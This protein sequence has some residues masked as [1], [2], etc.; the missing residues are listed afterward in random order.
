MHTCPANTSHKCDE[1]EA[2]DLNHDML[3]EIE[4]QSARLVKPGNFGAMEV[5]Q[6][7][8]G[9]EEHYI[10]RFTSEACAL[11]E[12]QRGV[13]GME[14]RALP[15]GTLVAKG[16]YWNRVKG[17]RRW[18]TR[19]LAEQERIFRL[20]WI[21]VPD[22]EMEKPSDTVKLPNRRDKQTILNDTCR[23]L[24]TPVT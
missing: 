19:K 17:A 12:D 20:R 6:E 15:Q 24:L 9:D 11:T 5:E 7:K 4:N 8:P 16:K 2:K 23:H 18:Y 1:L 10:I 22:V 21:V 13:E 14:D 3:A